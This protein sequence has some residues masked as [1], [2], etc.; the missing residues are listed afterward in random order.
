MSWPREPIAYSREALPLAWP[1]MDGF[2]SDCSFFFPCL[3]PAGLRLAARSSPRSQDS[4]TTSTSASSTPRFQVHIRNTR[5]SGVEK[6]STRGPLL[7]LQ[8]QKAILHGLSHTRCVCVSCV[9]VRAPGK[10]SSPN[11]S[12]IPINFLISAVWREDQQQA[13]SKQHIIHTARRTV[14]HSRA[15]AVQYDLLPSRR[16]LVGQ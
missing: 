12:S 5:A 10:T 7:Y 2:I 8:T 11:S 6:A 4:K 16:E 14:L 13:S 9:R 3:S 15:L 1:L